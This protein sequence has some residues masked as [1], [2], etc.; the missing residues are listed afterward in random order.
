ML[1]KPCERRDAGCL[2]IVWARWPKDLKRHRFCSLRCAALA[3]IAAMPPEARGPQLTPEERRRAG[4]AGGKAG[5][6]KRRAEAAQRIVEQM[7]AII[8]QRV[9][10]QLDP[11]EC[12][13][14]KVL[15]GRAW[16]RG[17]RT[18]YRFGFGRDERRK[19]RKAA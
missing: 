19:S 18:G 9:F 6:R 12:A 5:A 13:R 14:I 1:S 7:A 10:E 17:Y 4:I 8:P 2:G 16:T 15:I 11:Q 3:R